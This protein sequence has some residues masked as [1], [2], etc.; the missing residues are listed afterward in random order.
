[1]SSC[2]ISQLEQNCLGSFFSFSFALL[3]ASVPLAASAGLTRKPEA[4]KKK[5]KQQK[6]PGSGKS[7]KHCI[8]LSPE[9]SALKPP[10][11]LPTRFPQL[12][13]GLPSLIQ[14]QSLRDT[15]SLPWLSL[16]VRGRGTQSSCPSPPP[17][18][19]PRASPGVPL[20]FS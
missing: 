6:T 11:L 2:H 13:S 7:P 4:L 15:T 14:E 16:P 8:F 18:A 19:T 5:K 9:T 10:V 20:P 1:M 17:N 12:S 3:K